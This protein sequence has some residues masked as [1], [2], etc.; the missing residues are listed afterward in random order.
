M[1]TETLVLLVLI[2]FVLASFPVWPYAGSWGYGPS[3]IMVVLLI[4]F[5]IW[6]ISGERPLFRD[7]PPRIAS[8]STTLNSAADDIQAA[9]RELG[10]DLKNTGRNVAEA[11]RNTVQ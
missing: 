6:A 7:G 3:G 4:G 2:V 1:S 8:N 9:G 10:K 11:I 5:L